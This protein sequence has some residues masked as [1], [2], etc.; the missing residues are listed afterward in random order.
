MQQLRRQDVALAQHG[1]EPHEE[2]RKLESA[3]AR[4]RVQLQALE[5]R[6]RNEADPAKAAIFAAHAELLDDPDLR[7]PVEQAIGEGP[8]RGLRVARRPSPPRPTGSPR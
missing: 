4:A 2:R 5:A 6:L 7:E 3:L 1:D 8:E